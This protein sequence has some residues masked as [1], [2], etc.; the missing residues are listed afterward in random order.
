MEGVLKSWAVPKGPPTEPRIKRLAMQ[1]EDHP[2]EYGSF[3]GTIG[4]GE[5]GAGRVE[6]WDNGTYQL[7]EQAP[8]KLRFALDGKKLQGEY[9]LILFKEDRGRNL[10]LLFKKPAISSR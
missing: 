5:Y 7:L 8:R 9:E 10:W 1:V 6:I 4:K 2:L 3:E